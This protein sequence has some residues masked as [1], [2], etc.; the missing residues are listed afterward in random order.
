MGRTYPQTTVA[1][2]SEHLVHRD[3]QQASTSR[4]RYGVD[5]HALSRFQTFRVCPPTNQIVECPQPSHTLK[6]A[7]S[8]FCLAVQSIGYADYWTLLGREPHVCSFIQNKAGRPRVALLDPHCEPFESIQG[9]LSTAHTT[10]S[11]AKCSKLPTPRN[12]LS[13]GGAWLLSECC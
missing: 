9:V 5:L 4:I 11:C 1:L 10:N 7:V 6:C 13:V 3:E 2:L 8:P 12:K